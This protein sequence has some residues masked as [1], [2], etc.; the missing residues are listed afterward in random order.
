MMAPGTGEVVARGAFGFVQEKEVDSEE[1]VKMYLAGIRKYGELSKAGAI[2]FEYVYEAISGSRS[3]DKDT[4]QINLAIAQRWRPTLPRPAYF[5]GMKELLE[6]EFIYR[7][8]ATD[9][10]FV[11]VRFMFNGDRMVLVQSYRRKNANGSN[12]G[13]NQLSLLDDPDAHT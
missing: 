3:K 2:L 1:F 11:N 10:Y 7:S 6:K 4:V 8:L 13:K 9:V 12:A 5:K